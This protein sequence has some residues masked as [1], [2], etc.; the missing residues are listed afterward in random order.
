MVRVQLSHTERLQLAESVNR[1]WKV[2]KAELAPEYKEIARSAV[3]KLTTMR[4]LAEIDFTD[5]EA[6]VLV[7]GLQY[8]RSLVQYASERPPRPGE[9][10][11]V[12]ARTGPA[13]R[14]HL[15]PLIRK[16]AKALGEIDERTNPEL[17]TDPEYQ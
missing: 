1:W 13:E 2:R 8:Q 3:E 11:R 10:G 16:F 17:L 6:H 12:I 4:G 5:D 9:F 7:E 14:I 15:G